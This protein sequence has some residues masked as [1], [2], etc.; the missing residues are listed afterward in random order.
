[1]R[2]VCTIDASLQLRIHLSQRGVLS[3]AYNFDRFGYSYLQN[4]GRILAVFI[5]L[6]LKAGLKISTKSRYPEYL[7]GPGAGL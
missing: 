5:Y 3:R 7:K 1:M 4:P 2:D 6:G